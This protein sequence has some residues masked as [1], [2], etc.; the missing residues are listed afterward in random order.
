M[1]RLIMMTSIVS[2]VML[3]ASCKSKEQQKEENPFFVEWDTPYGVPPFDKIKNEHYLPAFEEAMKQHK[4]EIEAIVT[5]KIEPDFES[6]IAA[7]DYSGQMLRKVSSVFF[8]MTSSNTTDELQEIAKEV[9][10]MLSA[11]FDD[12]YLNRGLFTK[13]E[14]VWQQRESMNLTTEQMM[15]VELT[16]KDF[17]RSGAQLSEDKQSRLREIN[18]DLSVLT[19]QYGDNILAETNNYELVIENKDDLSGLPDAIIEAAAETAREKG[20]DGKWVFTLQNS[21]VIPFLQFAD[22]RELRK[23][24]QQAYIKRGDNNNEFD[25]KEI[26]KKIVS[27]RIER[28]QLLGYENHADF[29]LEMNMAENSENVFALLDQLW[30]PALKRAGDEAAE[31]QAIIKSEGKDF[32]LEA[33]DW[34]YYAEKLRKQKYNLNEEE[35]KPYFELSKVRDGIFWVCDQLYGIHFTV[36]TDIPKYHEDVVVYEVTN[37][38]KSHVGILYMDFHPRE[39]KRGGAWMDAF[40]EQYKKDGEM[41]SPVIT[42]VCNFTKPTASVPSLLTLDEVLTFFHEFG[43]ALHGLLSNGTYLGISG[44]SVS[45]DFVE[46]PSQIMEHWALEPEVLRHYAVH[47]KTGEPMPDEL[48]LKIQNA[49]YFDQGFATVEYLAASYLD[50]YWHTLTSA[51]GLDVNAFETEIMKKIGLMPQ[52]ISRY[53]STYFAHIFSSGYSAGYYGYIWSG[54]LDN[55]AFEAFRENGIFDKATATSFR[56]NILEKGH[57]DKAINLYKAFRGREPK[58]EPLLKSR[59]LI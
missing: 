21:S 34:R 14:T 59:G 8:N 23:E 39:S 15:L 3:M 36:R 9:A 57:S 49:S 12:I 46:L 10:P 25:N 4:A 44:T 31:Y 17:V 5:Q 7:Y 51:E 55:D 18:Q 24:I 50:M 20:K 47:Y 13:V 27:L 22:N 43:H 37:T 6:V 52:I 58:I 45:H 19:L 1:K 41:I 56:T 53:R 26:L 42:I 32:L 28:A 2:L 54:V 11:H 40:R 29:V 38:D 33:W 30:T 48:I 16:Y 35:L